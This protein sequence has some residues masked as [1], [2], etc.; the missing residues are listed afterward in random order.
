[1]FNIFK[2]LRLKKA[3]N[4]ALLR[5]LEVVFNEIETDAYT[6]FELYDSTPFSKA[7]ELIQKLK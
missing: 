1:M 4:Q 5:E 6:N 7:F 2:I 3:R